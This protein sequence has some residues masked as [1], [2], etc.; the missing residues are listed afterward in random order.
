MHVGRVLSLAYSPDGRWLASAGADQTIYLWNARQHRTV[1][2]YATPAVQTDLG[3]PTA[4]SFNPDGTRLALAIAHPD[5]TGE[6]DV[7]SVPSLVL[8]TRLTVT[9]GRQAQFS[10]DGW[11]LI[12]QD[13]SGQVWTF[14][15]RTW[16]V[17]GLPLIG[18]PQ[19]GDFTLAPDNRTLATTSADGTVQLWD[20][21][22]DHA[23]G[24]RLGFGVAQPVS[25]AVLAGG[26]A[27][28][29]IA[30]DG[31]GALWDLSP[32]SWET[33][34]CTIAGRPLTRAE[35]QDVLPGRTFA[36]ACAHGSN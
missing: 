14:D 31:N 23:I 34:A 12:Y 26:T 11:R 36:P 25:A 2:L 3:P 10:R 17:R 18:A 13:D 8:V 32:R 19:P 16:T 22:S 4:L 24:I 15:T 30:D 28:V 5:G 9:A 6:V 33:R 35:W 7:L 27:V 21:A 20:L 29:T 1:G